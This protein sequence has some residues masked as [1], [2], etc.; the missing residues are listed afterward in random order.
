MILVCHCIA[1]GLSNAVTV[2]VGN[3]LGANRPNVAKYI[4]YV[5]VTYSFIVGIIMGGLFT[6]FGRYVG[7]VVSHD[8]NVIHAY[9]IIAPLVGVSL[10][11]LSTFTVTIGVLIG[12]ARTLG[13]AI[14]ALISCWLISVPMSYI[15][16]LKLNYGIKGIFYGIMI[17][18]TMFFI[19]VLILFFTSNWNDIAYKAV[20]RSKKQT[21]NNNSI[22][23]NTTNKPDMIESSSNDDNNKTRLLTMDNDNDILNETIMEDELDT[24]NVLST[25]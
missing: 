12:Q 3:M 13:L 14:S 20:Q 25:K 5:G 15:L 10:F 17:G 1:I 9:K 24:N 22:N 11:L 4:A 23:N 8:S 21:N 2:R 19:F 16:G 18:Y 7:Y 6:L